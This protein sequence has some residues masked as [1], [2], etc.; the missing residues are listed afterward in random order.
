MAD[1]Y[2]RNNVRRY[3]RYICQKECRKKS[4]ECQEEEEERTTLMKSRDPASLARKSARIYA[5]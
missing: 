5:R 3:A 4:I 2:A 1:A